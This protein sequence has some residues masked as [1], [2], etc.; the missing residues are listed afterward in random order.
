M[1]PD[2]DQLC[3]SVSTTKHTTC[4][5]NP[6]KKQCTAIVE[7][8]YKDDDY[9]SSWSKIGWNE[10]SIMEYD[11]IA[12]ENHS[13]TATREERSRNENLETLIKRRGCKWT[14]EISAMTL[15][16]QKRHAKDC[17][18]S[19]QKVPDAETHQFLHSNKSDQGPDSP[20]WKYYVP[21]TMHSSSSSSSRTGG[22]CGTGTHGNL[23]HGVNMGFF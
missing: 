23:H 7:R 18:M 22:Q 4:S 13:Y 20:G 10:E 12:L 8:W 2:M 15:K 17:T 19:I 21:A 1:E 16:M 3:G 9:R 14:I 11:K 6:R 5:G